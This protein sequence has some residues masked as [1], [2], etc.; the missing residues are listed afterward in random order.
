MLDHVGIFFHAVLHILG[1]FIGLAKVK[2]FGQ[3]D[4][5]VHLSLV[6]GRHELEWDVFEQ[7]HSEKE[8]SYNDDNYNQ[9]PE[10]CL[11]N[12][13]HHLPVAFLPALEHS[14]EPVADRVLPG[15]M[16]RQYICCH[17]WSQ[18]KG[19]KYGEQSC[20]YYRQGK[21]HKHLSHQ[22]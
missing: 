20:E 10:L 18:C 5:Y 14:L 21:F 19:Y 8:Y 11:K 15:V 22:S 16:L 4:L 2:A 7:R 1:K 9:T 6:H 13:F 17:H 3:L 12:K